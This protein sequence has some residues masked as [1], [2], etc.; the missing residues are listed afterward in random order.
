MPGPKT[1]MPTAILAIDEMLLICGD[2]TLLLPVGR[3][4]GLRKLREPV[5]DPVPA[6]ADSDSVELVVST[7]VTTVLLGMPAPKTSICRAMSLVDA[8]PL[9]VVEFSTVVPVVLTGA[10]TPGSE[11][12]LADSEVTDNVVASMPPVCVIAASPVERIVTVLP[13]MPPRTSPASVSWNVMS[14]RFPTP[15]TLFA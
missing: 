5:P 4:E 14:P 6:G 3:L 8:R 7:L 12:A 13:V 11:M 1:S 2:P 15:S 9:T 10:A